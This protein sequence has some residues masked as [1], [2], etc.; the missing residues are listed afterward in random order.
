MSD[1]IYPTYKLSYYVDAQA[2]DYFSYW[3]TIIGEVMLEKANSGDVLSSKVLL[4]KLGEALKCGVMLPQEYANFLSES[5]LKTASGNDPKE[6]FHIK[7]TTGHS[8]ED[9]ISRLERVQI[10]RYAEELI[11]LDKIKPVAAYLIVSERLSTPDNHLSEGKVKKARYKYR[12]LNLQAF[13]FEM[14]H[15]GKIKRQFTE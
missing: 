1:D 4:E 5:L 7:Y 11:E 2:H 10:A 3:F 14:T 8:H 15:T 9:D 13:E 6:A 12:K